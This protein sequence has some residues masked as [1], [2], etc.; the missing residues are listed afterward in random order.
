MPQKLLQIAVPGPF[1]DGLTYL[2]EGHFEDSLIGRRVIVPL[3][4]RKVVG[5]IVSGGSSNVEIG[6]LKFII[7][8]LDEQPL[9]TEHLRNL[10]HFMRDYYHV[11]LGDAYY[12]ALPTLICKGKPLEGRKKTKKKAEFLERE[13]L[14]LN[15]EQQSVF[16]AI[17]NNFENFAV[18]LLE[19]VTGSGKTE[20]YLECV[21]NV[22][23]HNRSVLILVPEIGLMP[24]T[25][26]RFKRRLGCDI[27]AY[28]SGLTEAEKRDCWAGVLHGQIKIVVGTRSAVF[29]PFIDLGLIVIDEEH[30]TSYKQQNGVHYSAKSIALMRGKEEHCAVILGSATPSAESYYLAQKGIYQHHILKNRAIAQRR[31]LTHV[32]D[33]RKFHKEGGVSKPFLEAMQAH[34]QAGQQ[35]LV[36]LNRRGYAPIM[37]CEGCG[38]HVKCA[39]CEMSYTLHSTPPMLLC[40][41]CGRTIKIPQEC[42]KCSGV[43]CT[44]GQGTQQIE[45][46][47]AERFAAYPILRLDQDS[48]RKKGELEEKLAQI[49]NV[50]AKLIIGTQML[51]KGHDFPGISWVGI[52][53]LDYGF[54]APDFRGIERTGQL[55][56]QVAGRAG[57]GE[58][59]G[60]VMIQTHVPDHPLLVIL[61][62]E[63]Y[64]AFLNQLLEDRKEAN[65][66]PFRYLALLRAEAKN[67]LVLMRFLGT[68]KTQILE[69]FQVTVLGPIPAFL[70]KKNNYYRAQI[71]IESENRALL[72]NALQYLE[73]VKDQQNQV[74]L[75]IDVDPI[76][77]G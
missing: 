1:P 2:F 17:L 71:V 12:T 68:L 53:D 62:K 64:S 25:I 18:H 16:E 65:W 3:R 70:K 6:K 23:E 21:E 41:H 33:M 63:G 47:L 19:G 61:L 13:K 38:E 29:M 45:S 24:Q 51:A 66:P 60:E 77:I 35:V 9:I 42:D 8:I 72:H 57:R 46:F 67:N 27:A 76:E 28:H 14:L 32:I 31:N 10:I 37:M 52:I 5:I 43:L 49:K 58:K 15:K 40:H 20:V 48:T 69:H 44:I 34:L 39:A 22:L 30:D 75:W 26:E 11:S 4:K 36:F 73:Q 56:T 55:L 7:E 54:F 50:E 74:K 59:Q